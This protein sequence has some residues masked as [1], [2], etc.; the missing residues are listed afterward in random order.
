MAASLPSVNTES[1][2]SPAS[3]P[4]PSAMWSRSTSMTPEPC[5]RLPSHV[6][7][8]VGFCVRYASWSNTAVP[9]VDGTC[10]LFGCAGRILIALRAG[11][12][13][14]GGESCPIGLADLE[15]G[16]L[17]EAVGG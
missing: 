1:A 13:R 16:D 3:L 14:W 10:A 17:D 11:S 12:A 8:W 6:S 9:I 15:L 5:L 2:S 4:W 7:Y